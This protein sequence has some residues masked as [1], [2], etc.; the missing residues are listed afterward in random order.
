MKNIR[1]EV[2]VVRDYLNQY[3][4][5]IVCNSQIQLTE[6]IL[7]SCYGR[8]VYDYLDPNCTQDEVLY[9]R[10]VYT[11][12]KRLDLSCPHEADTTN[13]NESVCCR[14]VDAYED[15]GMRYYS[16]LLGTHYS[17]CVGRT[18]C[19][20]PVAWNDTI[21]NCNQSIYLDKTNYMRQ[22]YHCIETT[23]SGSSL[24]V[25]C[26]KTD[27]VYDCSSSLPTL[28]TAATTIAGSNTGTGSVTSSSGGQNNST[29]GTTSS[30]ANTVSSGQSTA[31]YALTP[32]RAVSNLSSSDKTSITVGAAIGALLAVAIMIAAGVIYKKW[33]KSKARVHA[34]E[35]EEAFG[36]IETENVAPIRTEQYKSSTIGTYKLQ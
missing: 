35:Y 25:T 16:D 34:D 30:G 13:R 2:D 15:C 11:Y 23:S 4:A 26:S 10:D 28:S 21:L 8:T 29:G 3:T 27:A 19:K 6:H 18:S 32:A 1:R 20:V 14:Y 12:A 36:D 22:Y 33:K 31:S 5:G 7:E 24:A 9:I 17:N